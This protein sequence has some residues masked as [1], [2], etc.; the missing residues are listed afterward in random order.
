MSAAPATRPPVCYPL[1]DAL[2]LPRAV[3]GLYARIIRQGCGGEF[4]AVWAH[5]RPLGPGRSG[6]EIVDEVTHRVEGDSFPEEYLAALGEGV[7]RAWK[8]DA[9]PRPAY[10]V[11]IRVTGARW[12]PVD[13]DSLSFRAV[14]EYLAAEIT[15]C[16]REG[17][18]PRP[19][20]LPRTRPPLPWE[21]DLLHPEQGGAP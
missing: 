14:G 13:S 15:A 21:R 9:G 18:A 5:A 8:L 10:S 20:V 3:H 17:R 4:A 2:P 12:H 19:L 16:L 1:P 11:R 7:H 6:V